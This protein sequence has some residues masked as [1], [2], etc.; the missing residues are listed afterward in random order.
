MKTT[1]TSPKILFVNYD[2]RPA[3]LC[4]GK[5]Y[6]VFRPGEPWVEW[7]YFDISQTGALMDDETHWRR[8]FA[9]EGY[10]RLNVDAWRP[11]V[12]DNIPQDKPLPRKKDFDEAAVRMVAAQKVRATERS[13]RSNMASPELIKHMLANLSAESIERQHRHEYHQGHPHLTEAEI[14]LMMAAEKKQN[15]AP[16]SIEEAKRVLDTEAPPTAPV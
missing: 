14:D 3:I 10:Y 15:R 2:W 5:A 7:D 12:Q 13:K 4:G 16:A 9:R 11:I 1:T 6:V 8:Y